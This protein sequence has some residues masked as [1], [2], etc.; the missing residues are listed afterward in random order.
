MERYAPLPDWMPVLEGRGREMLA[1]SCFCIAKSGT[2]TLEAALLGC[3][4]LMAYA[5]DW[6]SAIIART[7]VR[8]NRHMTH[9]SLPNIIAGREVIP[10]FL[11]EECTGETLSAFAGK[12]LSDGEAYEKM[13]RDLDEVR[14]LVGDRDAAETAAHALMRRLGANA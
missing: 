12:M 5:G 1:D 6:L 2:T 8:F 4:L 9:Y 14:R 7:I 11:Q 10:E 3:P 13:R